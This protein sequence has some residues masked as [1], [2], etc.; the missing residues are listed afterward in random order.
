M[1][2]YSI[3]DFDISPN[4]NWTAFVNWSIFMGEISCWRVASSESFSSQKIWPVDKKNEAVLIYD[5]SEDTR[6]MRKNAF[7]GALWVNINREQI[8]TKVVFVTLDSIWTFSAN[9][10]EIL[11]QFIEVI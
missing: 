9:E 10:S 5:R 1:R 3:D 8:F 4:E 7:S 6:I 2:R 11:I